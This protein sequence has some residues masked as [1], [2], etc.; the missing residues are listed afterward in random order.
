MSVLGK[1]IT[2]VVWFPFSKHE[3]QFQLNAS[4][5]YE[6]FLDIICEEEVEDREEFDINVSIK[7]DLQGYNVFIN[8]NQLKAASKYGNCD[9]IFWTN[10]QENDLISVSRSIDP[11]SPRYHISLLHKYVLRSYN[12][13]ISSLFSLQLDKLLSGYACFRNVP[14][15]RFGSSPAGADLDGNGYYRSVYVAV[16]EQLIVSDNRNAFATIYQLFSD[17]YDAHHRQVLD[18]GAQVE[19][20]EE[21]DVKELLKI[22]LLAS[23]KCDYCCVYV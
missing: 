18:A 15:L 1:N 2:V 9:E 5:T 17:C 13:S 22:L 20:E 12:M 21:E 11:V 14:N 8:K 10:I 4:T 19:E 3:E 7:R 16:V 6:E 23:S